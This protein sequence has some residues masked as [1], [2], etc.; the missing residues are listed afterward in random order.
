MTSNHLF[1]VSSACGYFQ[2]C[3]EKSFTDMVRQSLTGFAAI[4]FYSEQ[5]SWEKQRVWPFW[6]IY[7]NVLVIYPLEYGVWE[8]ALHPHLVKL[9]L[10]MQ[11]S[12]I[13]LQNITRSPA[14]I[15]FAYKEYPQA[16]FE[17]LC[18]RHLDSL[19]MFWFAFSLIHAMFPANIFTVTWTQY[20]SPVPPLPP[21][22]QTSWS[23]G[24]P[25]SG[26]ACSSFWNSQESS[27]ILAQVHPFNKMVALCMK[28]L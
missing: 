12:S 10:M 3:F 5:I 4:V 1:S 27:L 20:S 9:S 11:F 28:C 13:Q 26:T 7:V 2:A 14:W 24:D 25:S 19:N 17:Y 22:S 16:F 23:T 6:S 8:V 15:E 18:I 21:R